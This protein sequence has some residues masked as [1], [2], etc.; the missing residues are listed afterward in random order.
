M[1]KDSENEEETLELRIKNNKNEI[2]QIFSNP[3]IYDYP[4]V[5][6]SD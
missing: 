6:F 5:N 4:P 1:D 3:P 2:N